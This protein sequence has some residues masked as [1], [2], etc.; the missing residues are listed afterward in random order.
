MKMKAIGLL[1]IV[2]TFILQ[3]RFAIT[4]GIDKFAPIFE[5]L[6]K[7]RADLIVESKLI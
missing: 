6:I 1:A 7:K 2:I 3:T 4:F 5:N